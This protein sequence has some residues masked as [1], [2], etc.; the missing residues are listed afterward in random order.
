MANAALEQAIFERIMN[1][2]ILVL[3][4]YSLFIAFF[5]PTNAKA[6]DVAEIANIPAWTS[7]SDKLFAQAQSGDTITR[8]TDAN[9]RYINIKTPVDYKSAA[10]R[11]FQIVV[12]K[13]AQIEASRMGK[14]VINVVRGVSPVGSALI[15]GSVFVSLLCSETEICQKEGTNDLETPE[16][17]GYEAT[18]SQALQLS[19]W[20]RNGVSY[21]KTL[22]ELKSDLGCGGN[23]NCPITLIEQAPNFLVITYDII[24]KSDGANVGSAAFNKINDGWTLQPVPKRTPTES[25]LTAAESKITSADWDQILIDKGVA[26]PVTDS[27]TLAPLSTTLSTETATNKDESGNV[28]GTTTKTTTLT[29]SDSATR[30]RPGSV[31][32]TE[33][34]TITNYNTSNQ[35]TSST[36]IN[37]SAPPPDKPAPPVNVHFDSVEDVQLPTQEISA[38]L[39]TTS[40]GEGACPA[41]IAVNT[42]LKSFTIPTEQYCDFATASRPFVL[43]IAGISG[44]FIITG[45]RKND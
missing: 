3:A 6:S 18:E 25:D 1:F 33:T 41:P 20:V 21:Q 45:F 39:N 8:T 22:E 44:L 11:A 7:V 26:L 37:Q 32:A 35:V 36:T 31:S 28:T 43:L 24:R 34:Q 23:Y 42:S 2:L 17:S 29:L 15:L 16:L 13:T 5:Y 10:G 4:F 30:A 40:W 12:D 38:P 14:A 27:P 9:G 19:G